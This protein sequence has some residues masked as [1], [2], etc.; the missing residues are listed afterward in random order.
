MP[1]C[2][3]CG[4]ELPVNEEGMAPVL[5]DRCAGRA[6][7]RARRG[8]STGTMRDYPATTALLAIN[9][10]VY[11]GMILTSGELMGFSG[12]TLVKWGGNFGPLTAGGEYWRLVTAGFVHANFVHVAIN[13]WC[14]W[15]LGRLSERLFGRWQTFAIYLLTGVGGALLSIGWNPERLSV[16]ASGAV[17]GVAGAL[18][19]GLKF[20][21]LNISAGEKKSIISSM[22]FFIVLSFSFGMRGNVDN[23]CHL[24]GFMTGLLIGVPLGAFAQHH[25]IYQLATLLVTAALLS[26]AGRELVQRN[27]GN[28]FAT[29]VAVAMQLKDYPKVIRLLEQYVAANPGDDEALVAL[30][31]AYEKNQQKDR[32][33]AAYQQAL[34]ANPTSA[35]AKQALDEAQGSS[36]APK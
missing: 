35:E 3:K 12:Q 2:L 24:G 11:V 17:F 23:M 6:T 27:G 19:A 30:G 22:I 32:A 10:A 20:G 25:K 14:L 21:N 36:P 31:D 28:G 7:T 16:G 33:I 18:L 29:R 13:M 15:S 5:C 34:K 8:M 4:A 1:Q 9:L 26:F